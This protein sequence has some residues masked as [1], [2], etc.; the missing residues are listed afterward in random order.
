MA[1]V[2][3]LKALHT[4]YAGQGFDIIGIS[5]DEDRGRWRQAL[6]MHHLPGLQVI[7]GNNQLLKDK[8][9]VFG[10]PHRCLIDQDGRIIA[11]GLRGA[12]LTKKIA[13][14]LKDNY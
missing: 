14:L 5:I 6:K 8:Y 7:A 10:I 3:A 2:P 4:E 12:E 13:E 1:Q 9:A 11:N